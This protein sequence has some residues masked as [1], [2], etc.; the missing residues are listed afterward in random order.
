MATK[1]LRRVGGI[2]ED[3][4]HKCELKKIFTCKEFLSYSDLELINLLDIPW[5]TVKE[6]T[7]AV[8]AAVSPPFAT[9]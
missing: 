1:K 3:L 5:K 8:S 6:L 7:S 9:V 2:H 4:L